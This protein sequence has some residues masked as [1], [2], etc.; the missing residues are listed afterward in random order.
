M[1]FFGARIIERLMY[2]WKKIG[3]VFL[4][5]RMHSRSQMPNVSLFIQ[6][7]SLHLVLEKGIWCETGP[8]FMTQAITP[9][10]TSVYVSR[11]I[12]G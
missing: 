4:A 9:E 7:D 6:V 11:I 2:R 10:G 12:Y 8:C 1:G 5:D 3:Q